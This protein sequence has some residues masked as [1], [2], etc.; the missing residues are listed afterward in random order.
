MK[1]RIPIPHYEKAKLIV[2]RLH[3][4][5]LTI[6][7]GKLFLLK[8]YVT[9]T[10]EEKHHPAREAEEEHYLLREAAEGYRLKS[11]TG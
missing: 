6:N 10:E 2:T 5:I 8:H 3:E 4:E 11:E 9:D 1:R 7:A